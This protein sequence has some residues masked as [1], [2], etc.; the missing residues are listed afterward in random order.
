MTDICPIVW[1]PKELP[2]GLCSGTNADGKCELD[3]TR[4]CAWVMIYSKLEETKKVIEHLGVW[5]RDRKLELKL[6]QVEWRQRKKIRQ[7]Y[8]ASPKLNYSLCGFANC[9]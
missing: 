4:D 6:E 9:G 8:E 5:L 1:C 3:P 7:I 2:N